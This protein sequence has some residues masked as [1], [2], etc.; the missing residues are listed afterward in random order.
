M[1]PLK[2]HAEPDADEPVT[3]FFLALPDGWATLDVDPRT[4]ARSVRWQL[5]H[6]QLDHPEVAAHRHIIEQ[7]LTQVAADAGASGTCFAACWFTVVGQLP[8]QASVAVSLTDIV[9]GPSTSEGMIADLVDVHD[10]RSVAVVD[11]GDDGPNAVRR[12]GRRRRTLP[13]QREEVEY[14]SHQVYV[15]VP[16]G[17]RTGGR[18]VAILSFAT[19]TLELEEELA[20]LF[21]D[22]AATFRFTTLTG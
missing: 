13:G 3:G 19:P 20:G 22:M 18:T 17:K 12:S 7:A 5:D 14:L 9:D 10:G 2:A 6:A 11:L 1:T 21:D 4:A 15:P 8:V 16:G